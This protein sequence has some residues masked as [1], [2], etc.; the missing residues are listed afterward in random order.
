MWYV[1][2]DYILIHQTYRIA[3]TWHYFVEFIK[4]CHV[5]IHSWCCAWLCQFTPTWCW[6][7]VFTRLQRVLVYINCHLGKLFT[8]CHSM[9]SLAHGQFSQKYLQETPHSLR[10]IWG[11]DMVY[12][13]Q[14]QSWTCGLPLSLLYCT[15]HLIM[16]DHIDVLMQERRNCSANALELRLSCINTS[17]S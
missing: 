8:W 11:Q 6:P 16:L 14:V 7:R 17:I 1:N 10:M 2:K 12:L 5:E 3:L 13:L 9:V 4:I 15:Q